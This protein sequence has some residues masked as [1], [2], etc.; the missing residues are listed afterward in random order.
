M[1]RDRKGEERKGERGR[2]G[3]GK[4]RGGGRE[5]EGEGEE[6][7]QCEET[8]RLIAFCRNQTGK[9]GI[10]PDQELMHRMMLN[11]LIH[12]GLWLANIS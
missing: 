8:H 7:H 2:G 3:R 4:G 9:P 6:R 5:G 1:L 12:C 10:Y 11:Q